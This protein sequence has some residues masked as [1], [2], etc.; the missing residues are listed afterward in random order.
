MYTVIISISE[1]FLKIVYHL[2]VLLLQLL[3]ENYYKSLSI[4]GVLD[5]KYLSSQKVKIKLI[6]IVYN[7]LNTLMD[8]KIWLSAQ[9]FWGKIFLYKRYLVLSK[10]SENQNN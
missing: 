7:I 9:G 2:P 4:T 3:P 6:G 1:H 5:N 8:I 10:Y